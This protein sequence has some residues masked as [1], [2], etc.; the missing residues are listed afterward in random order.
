MLLIDV[1]AYVSITR[2][3]RGHYVFPDEYPP[4]S[5]DVFTVAAF[6]SDGNMAFSEIKEFHSQIHRWKTHQL[7]SA[8]C[9]QLLGDPE[10]IE[11]LRNKESRYFRRSILK[12]EVA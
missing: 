1:I 10:H 6:R 2:E 5:R 9:D 11:H 8:Y 3:K 7:G 4:M 12:D